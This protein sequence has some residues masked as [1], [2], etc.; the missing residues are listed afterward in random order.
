ML[1]QLSEHLQLTKSSSTDHNSRITQSAAQVMK[2]LNYTI[3]RIN[4]A[5]DIQS[6]LKE[7]AMT[8]DDDKDKQKVE[9]DDRAFKIL[10]GAAYRTKNKLEVDELQKKVEWILNSELDPLG[11]LVDEVQVRH[12]LKP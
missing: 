12:K 11:I 3:L 1:T 7:E 10:Q 6:S 9:I 8:K 4:P 2:E 5:S